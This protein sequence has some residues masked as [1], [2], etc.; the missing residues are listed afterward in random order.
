MVTAITTTK[1]IA[2]VNIND[3]HKKYDEGDYDNAN[4]DI[5]TFLILMFAI[6][7]IRTLSVSTI[8]NSDDTECSFDERN[9]IKSKSIQQSLP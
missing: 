9:R 2:T 1:T 7:L 6:L 8:T 4:N 5:S 3:S